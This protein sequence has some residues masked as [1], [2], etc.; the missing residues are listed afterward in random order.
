MNEEK[1]EDSVYEESIENSSSARRQNTDKFHGREE[2]EHGERK[3]GGYEERRTEN[4]RERQTE[5][6]REREREREAAPRKT[7]S[8]QYAAGHLLIREITIMPHM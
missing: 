3:N 7:S 5:R 2:R 8:N 6:E 4:M 1:R